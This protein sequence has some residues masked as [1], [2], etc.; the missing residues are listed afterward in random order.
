MAPI[1]P[2]NEGFAL[3]DR[4]ERSTAEPTRV[5][6][7]APGRRVIV[8]RPRDPLAPAQGTA[9]R[10]EAE[11]RAPRRVSHPNVV[12]VFEHG[13]GA[14]DTPFLRMEHVRGPS[15]RELILNEGPLSLARIRALAWQLLDG[16][17]AIHAAGIVHADIKCDNLV[18]D[19]TGGGDRLLIIDLG[20]ARATTSRS[21][22]LGED[23]AA[24]TPE[25]LAPELVRGLP[26]TAATDLYS[27]AIVIYE[28]IVGMTPFAGR[29]PLEVLEHQVAAPIVFPEEVRA[30]ISPEVEGVLLRALEK[31]PER[32]F[33]DAHKLA[34]ALDRAIGMLPGSECPARTTE[35]VRPVPA[36]DPSRD[37]E[38]DTVRRRRRELDEA[39]GCG[40]P[41]PII[42][43]YLGLAD[44]LIAADRM[45]A[46]L[47]ELESALALLF[48]R[49]GGPPASLWRIEALL[50]ALYELLGNPVRARRVAMD[51]HTH[52]V[53]SGCKVAERSTHA[54]LQRLM[55]S[56]RPLQ[57]VD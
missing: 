8:Q 12:R 38:S 41:E 22:V 37:L 9:P 7:Y 36:R 3:G 45:G 51:A 57:R 20:P 4:L 33:P 52:A 31:E 39:L 1:D 30:V 19:K 16:L 44:A 53:R 46:A 29:R 25:Y 23:L 21:E 43:A 24:G 2:P 40:A 55:S 5:G 18:V 49:R 17:A 42:V 11:A 35:D 26:P 14:D 28:L 54:L 6:R 32:R 47:H 13:I 15:L 27:A 34:I 10:I 48:A 56:R 50:A